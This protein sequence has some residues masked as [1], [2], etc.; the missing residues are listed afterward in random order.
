[1]LYGMDCQMTNMNE[2]NQNI[3]NIIEKIEIDEIVKN[4]TKN[5]IL[6]VKKEQQ[7]N[8]EKKRIEKERIFN[9]EYC[10]QLQGELLDQ[11]SKQINIDGDSM[12]I[13]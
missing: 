2:L 12:E 8:N 6:E 7:E 3:K 10:N 4:N 5:K 1:M 11:I 9:T 13:L